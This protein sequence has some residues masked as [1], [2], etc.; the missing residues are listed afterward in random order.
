MKTVPLQLGE[1]VMGHQTATYSWKLPCV[2]T[3]RLILWQKV[4]FKRT[5]E[6]NIQ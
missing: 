4:Q 1:K 2:A 3:Q 5:S 6:I